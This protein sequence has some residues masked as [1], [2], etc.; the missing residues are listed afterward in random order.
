MLAKKEL[1]LISVAY[2]LAHFLTTLTGAYG[3]FRDELYYIACSHHLGWGYVDQPPFSIFLLALNRAVF[4]DSLFALR[5]LPAIS[6]AAFVFVTGWIASELG[7]G[8]FAQMLAAISAA[9]TPVYL[10]IF[11]FYSM[12]S[13]D[14]LFCAL[15]LLVVLLIVNSGNEKLWLL[16]GLLVGLGLQNKLSILFLCVGLGAGMLFSSHRRHLISKWFWL[17]AICAAVINIPQVVW[18][19]RNHWPTLEFMRNATEHKNAQISP[20]QF[21]LNLSLLMHPFNIVIWLPGLAGLLFLPALR[22]YRFLFILFVS[23]TIIFILQNGK[24]YYL[25][26]FFP[27]LFAAGGVLIEHFTSIQ[28]KILRPILVILLLTGG[29]ISA[30]FA[31]P[32]LPVETYIRYAK[33]MGQEPH[34][35]ERDR[36]GKLSQHFADMFGWKE[37]AETVAPVYAR[38]S[39]EEKS[40]CGIFAD[41]YGEAAAIDFFGPKYSL[42]GAVSGHNSYWLWGPGKSTGEV[43]I[44]IGGDLE[45]HQP[46]YESCSLEATHRNEYARSFES[47]LSIFVCRKLKEPIPKVWPLTRRYI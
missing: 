18:E 5:L 7:G 42:P 15:A 33:F 39:P 34:S 9:I 12:N 46:F 20:A 6:G 17:G 16:F 11:N 1:L 27:A 26:P 38:L 28:M 24:P 37:M 36:P 40:K 44:I 41:N 10:S 22:K 23:V 43:M 4:G 45:D 2:L 30:P 47:D 25:S 3:Y 13:F 32:F 14:L 29:L 8:R 31:L 21:F 19:V 35:E